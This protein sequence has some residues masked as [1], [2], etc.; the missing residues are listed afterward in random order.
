MNGYQFTVSVFYWITVYRFRLL[1]ITSLQYQILVD[2][3]HQSTVAG[4]QWISVIS[5]PFQTFS[6]YHAV[7]SLLYRTLSEYRLSVYR[8]QLLVNISF[9]FTVSDFQ[10]ISVIILSY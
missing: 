5:L 9:Q 7:I 2:V 10:W 4:F 6:D 8:I 3:S 1:V